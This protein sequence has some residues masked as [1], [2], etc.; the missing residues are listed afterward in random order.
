MDLK[1]QAEDIK[2]P[3]LSFK[4]KPTTYGSSLILNDSQSN[5]N[6]DEANKSETKKSKLPTRNDSSSTDD[7]RGFYY[8]YNAIL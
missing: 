8:R 3:Y 1:L 4:N 2:L 7:S 6:L 5:F